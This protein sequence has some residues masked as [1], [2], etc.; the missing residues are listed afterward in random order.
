[1]HKAR[2]TLIAAASIAFGSG[3]VAAVG[4]GLLAGPIAATVYRKPELV[5]SLLLFATAIPLA[6]AA[7]LISTLQAFQTVRYTVLIKYLWEPDG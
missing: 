5:L 7:V 1:M 2:E 4:L 6:T 3:L